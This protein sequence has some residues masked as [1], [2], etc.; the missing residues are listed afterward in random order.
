MSGGPLLEE[1]RTMSEILEPLRSGNAADYASEKHDDALIN[2]VALELASTGGQ[3]LA[4]YEKAPDSL[5]GRYGLVTVNGIAKIP[6]GVVNAVKHNIDNPMSA[7]GTIGMGAGMAV[8]LKAVLPEAGP[9]GRIAGLA[10]GAYFTYKAAEPVIG[11]YKLAGAATTLKEIDQ[12]ATQI[13]NAGGTFIVDSAIAGIGYKAGSALA[14]KVLAMPQL[15]GYVQARHNFYEGLGNK[16]ADS[17]GVAP[18]DA[19]AHHH[20]GVIPPYLL[21]ELSLRN[22]QNSDFLSTR[23]KTIEIDKHSSPMNPRSQQDFKGAREVYDAQG[24]EVQPGKKVR[25]EGDKPSGN[26]EADRAYE[27][28][29]EVRDFYLKEFG[30]NGIDGKGMKYVSTVNYGQ[31]FENA[32][33][34]GKQ[35]TYGRPGP[36]S[37]FKTF[38]LRDIAAHEI[39]H[40]VTEMEAKLR[41]HG[42]AG[43]LNESHSDVFGALVEQY[44]K[45]QTADK[46]SWLMGEGIW[47]E[48]VK[49]RALRDMANPG[50]AYNDPAIGRDPQ[51]A[52]MDKYIK[53]WSDNGGVHLNSGIPNK[54]FVNFAKAVGGNAWE[55]PGQIWFEARRVSGSNPSFSQFAQH[56]IDVATKLGHSGEVPKL[57]AAWKS[58]G[59]T[60]NI[61]IGDVLTPGAGGGAEVVSSL[62]GQWLKNIVAK[63]KA[64]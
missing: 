45:K 49:G 64:G 19:H 18:L 16:F 33:W 11:A 51:P 39:A 54:A 47:K 61:N 27:Y 28:T 3:K 9:A 1:G 22:P 48:N 43:A 60:P 34:D 46:A 57:E 40:G 29:G 53:T 24:Q 30:R 14:T 56:T 55:K 17:L 2:K 25:F 15:S 26:I 20:H 41:Y 31:N 12:A 42:Q 5:I 13:G 10:L 32:F 6:E 7:L 35:M 8:A 4:T 63:K 21:D 52:H 58:V 44:T 23:N 37:P 38:V 59:V 36:D 50:T 62:G